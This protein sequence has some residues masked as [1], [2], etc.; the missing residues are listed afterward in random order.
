MFV[1]FISFFVVKLIKQSL[2]FWHKNQQFHEFQK[3]KFN[4]LHQLY[5]EGYLKINFEQHNYLIFKPIKIIKV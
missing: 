5:H 4:Y 1:Q 2:Y 3:D